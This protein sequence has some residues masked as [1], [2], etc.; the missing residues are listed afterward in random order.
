MNHLAVL[1]AL[2]LLAAPALAGAQDAMD[3]GEAAQQQVAELSQQT[4]ERVSEL[5]ARVDALEGAPAA[6]VEAR[7]TRAARA[8]EIM[9]RLVA[10][11]R[12]LALGQQDISAS[13]EE[14]HAA[15]QALSDDAAAQGSRTEALR[16]GEALQA[17]TYALEA[18]GREDLFQARSGLSHA[19]LSLGVARDLATAG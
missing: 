17:V 6:R 5:E 11:E 1:G 19:V 15:L 4:A 16:A 9:D 14:A 10:L 3:A 7:N 18:L 12:T 2:V 8:R 13:L